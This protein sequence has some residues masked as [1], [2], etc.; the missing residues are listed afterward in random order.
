MT[1]DEV[2]IDLDAIQ[3]RVD[4]V[5]D[6]PLTHGSSSGFWAVGVRRRCSWTT[7]LLI[8]HDPEAE[9]YADLFAHARDD[10]RALLAEVERLRT[11]GAVLMSYAVHAEDCAVWASTADCMEPC[12]CGFEAVYEPVK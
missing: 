7:N 4:A 5:G 11:Q 1:D 9:Q 12:S 10:I 6:E 2:R 8:N 3:A